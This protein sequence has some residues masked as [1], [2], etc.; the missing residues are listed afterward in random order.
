[1]KGRRALYYLELIRKAVWTTGSNHGRA[2]KADPVLSVR[3][4]ED[5]KTARNLSPG[6]EREVEK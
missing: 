3:R 1:M 6:T 4:T 5:R 2:G